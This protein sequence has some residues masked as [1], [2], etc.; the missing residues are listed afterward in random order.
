M[1]SNAIGQPMANP[2]ARLHGTALPYH[3]APENLSTHIVV[4]VPTSEQYM[5]HTPTTI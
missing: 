5:L 4:S 3:S 2:A 1:Q